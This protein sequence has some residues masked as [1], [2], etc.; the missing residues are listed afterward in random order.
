MHTELFVISAL[1]GVV[2]G[3]LSGT[4]GLGGGVVVVPALLYVFHVLDFDSATLAQQAVATSLAC[5]IVTSVSA[6]S[7]HYRHGA[8]R[9][10]LVVPLASGVLVG[11]FVGALF[12]S[13]LDGAALMRWFGVLS[14]LV[15]AQMFFFGARVPAEDLPERIPAVPGRILSGLLIGGVSAMF[16]I[17]GGSMTVPLMGA[18]RVRIQ[19]AVATSAAC[20]LPIALAGCAGF[21]VGGWNVTLP[22]GSVGFIYLPAVAGIVVTS[23]PMAWVGARFAHRLPAKNLKRLFSLVLFLIGLKLVFDL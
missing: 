1:V 12:A 3:L 8:L 9:K 21:I 20:G 19:Y 11:A 10:E 17:G 15:A 6:V 13:H 16:G 18:W 5:M 14:L 23:F 2:A 7:A 4:L 22:P